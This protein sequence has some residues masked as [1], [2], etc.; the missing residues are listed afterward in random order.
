MSGIL[1]SK[2]RTFDTIITSEGKR[3]LSSGDFQVKFVTFTDG[4]AFYQAD[5]ASGSAP[6]DDRLYLEASS[7]PQ[8]RVIIEEDVNALRNGD[9]KTLNGQFLSASLILSG[10]DFENKR[11]QLIQ[12]TVDNFRN[13]Y[14]LGTID[15]MYGDGNFTLSTE[16]LTFELNSSRNGK[17]ININ[18]A[19][20]F[21][22]DKRMSHLQNFQYLP[23]VT[24][25]Q[26]RNE[27]P[28]LLADYKKLNQEPILK[29][30]DINLL[31]KGI[32]HQ[33]VEFSETSRQNNLLAQFF[34]TKTNQME[35]LK[36]IEFGEFETED[37]DYP[38][39][40]VYF[41][42]KVFEDNTQNP[43]FINMFTLVFE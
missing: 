18:N 23:P 2:T 39:K 38:T 19:E 13:L 4:A 35:K 8:D 29:S 31:L 14:T 40:K 32:P 25:P 28:Q 9:T 5:I 37:L 1:D 20:S 34:E 11:Q 43:T 27:E 15:P 7:L 3:Q 42:G 12:S 26:F 22:E 33:V 41:V 21:F 16:E 17:E 6:A 24:K 36:V 10:T 30:K